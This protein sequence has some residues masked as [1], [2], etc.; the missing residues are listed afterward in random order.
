[1]LGQFNQTA[2][3]PQQAELV[4]QWPL[5]GSLKALA[6]TQVWWFQMHVLF[7]NDL[8]T[9]ANCNNKTKFKINFIDLLTF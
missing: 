1:M 5:S 6:H 8:N 4:V 7:Y 9:Q 2:G 3:H